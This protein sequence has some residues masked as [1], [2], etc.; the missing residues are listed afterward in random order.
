MTMLSPQLHLG[1]PGLHSL[2]IESIYTPGE[3]SKPWGGLWTSTFIP[4]KGSAWLTYCASQDFRPLTSSGPSSLSLWLLTPDP[5]ARVLSLDTQADIDRLFHTY[6]LV[7]L[8]PR[9]PGTLGLDWPRLARDFDAL[10]LT[11]AGFRTGYPLFSTWSCESTIW[12]RDC[13]I[14]K[15]KLAELSWTQ[16]FDLAAA[17]ALGL[18]EEIALL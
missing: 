6:S 7:T 18:T 11:Q 9:T 13:F 12:F 2:Q 16:A 8:T 15:Q 5:A 14:A 3:F 1:P 10:H 4:G 17:Q